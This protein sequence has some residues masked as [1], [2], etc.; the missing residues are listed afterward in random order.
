MRPPMKNYI[1]PNDT[2]LQQYTYKAT[3]TI[4]YIDL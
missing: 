1:E 2:Y 3:S 4:V